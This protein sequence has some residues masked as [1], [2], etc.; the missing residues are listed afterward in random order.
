MAR[1]RPLLTGAI[2]LLATGGGDARPHARA[3]T[4]PAPLVEHRATVFSQR[5]RYVE[6]GAGPALIL[7]HGLADSLEVWRAEIDVL[8][9]RHRVV[10][11]DQI[12]FGLS[13]KPLLSYRAQ[14]LVDFLDEF[15][16]V[17]GVQHATLVGNSLGGWIAALMSIEHPERIDALILVDSAGMASLP[18]A[19]GPKVLRA[20]RL[21][22]VEDLQVLGPLSFADPRFYTPGEALR[23][24]FAERVAAGDGYTIGQIMDS[25]SRGDDVLDGQ[26]DRIRCPTLVVWGREDRLIPL[27]FAEQLHQG[28]PGSRLTVLDR[29]GHEPQVECPAAFGGVLQDFLSAP[30]GRAQGHGISFQPRAR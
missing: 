4:S 6:A 25:I 30:V 27:R 26:L 22:S 13:D 12:G 11:L 1:L 24:A 17:L 21:A 8:A 20:L 14:T 3:D 28:I 23:K 2:A 5:I 19:L 16:R 9:R 29:C 10:A 18:G 7:V 15:M